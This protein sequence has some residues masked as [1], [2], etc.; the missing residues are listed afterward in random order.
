MEDG[1]GAM[2]LDAARQANATST[3][4]EE[5]KIGTCR[6]RKNSITEATIVFRRLPVLWD[7]GTHDASIGVG[8]GGWGALGTYVAGAFDSLARVREDICS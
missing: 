6:F 1:F 3:Y 2:P 4:P 8:V 7:L 5:I